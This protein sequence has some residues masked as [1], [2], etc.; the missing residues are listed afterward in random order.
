MTK[1][2]TFL[3]MLW[4]S[5]VLWFVLTTGMGTQAADEWSEQWSR[6]H[7][8][9]RTAIESGDYDALPESAKEKIDAEKFAKK[10]ERYGEMEEK[11]AKMEN[12]IKAGDFE[13][14]KSEMANNRA[15]REA[16]IL[17]KTWEIGEKIRDRI[18]ERL[19]PTEEELQEKFNRLTEYYNENDEL[20]Q[21][22]RW[23]GKRKGWHCNGGWGYGKSGKKFMRGGG[24]SDSAVELSDA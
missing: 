19:D 5:L 12:I 22:K 10:V 3:T 24:A 15:E 6:D 4:V 1:T 14:F 21:G 11:K 23:F 9:I 7:G 20:P 13:S 18:G 16:K 17:E 2:L 8:E